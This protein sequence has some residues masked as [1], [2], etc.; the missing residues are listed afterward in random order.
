[1]NCE[2]ARAA[3]DELF[4]GEAAPDVDA[5]LQA[6]LPGCAT[7]RE[8]YERLAR[9]D[10][11]LAQGELSAPR[12]DQLEARLFAR[13]PVEAP[14]PQ[15]T[16]WVRSRGWAVAL[17]AAVVALVVAVPVWRLTREDP[18]SPRG[19]GGDAWGVRAFCVGADGKVTSEARAGGTLRC[20]AG[21]SVQFTYTAPRGAALDL[22]L[23]GTELRLFPADGASN[24]ITGG[25]DVAL[26]LSTPVGAWLATPQ[27]VT[28]RFTDST[29]V[30]VST[31]TLT[32]APP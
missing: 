16:S 22:S 14:P 4:A 13:L 7:C 5:A 11:V 3:M 27:V 30:L 9:V 32:L 19:T 12:L 6:H 8:R 28:A 23:D 21:S 25:V 1:M 15:P 17:A 31:S 24:A 29:G 18:F 2:A 10:A 26:P 20:G